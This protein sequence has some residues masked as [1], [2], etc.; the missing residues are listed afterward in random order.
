MTIGSVNIEPAIMNAACSVAKSLDDVQQLATTNIGA[1][2][3]G[4]IT[5]DARKG[6]PTPRWHVGE[7]YALNSFGMP[8]DGAAFYKENLP[9]MIAIAHAAKKKFILSIAGFKTEDYRQLAMLAD[10]ANVDAIELNLG[11][12]NVSINGEQKQ[13]ASFDIATIQE[14]IEA[15]S[16]V[17]R[18]PFTLKLSPYSNPSE[19]KAVAEAIIATDKVSGVVTSNTFANSYMTENGE[20]VV[21]SMFGGLSGHSLLPISLGQVKQ[22]RQILPSHISVI[23]VGGIES[24]EDVR[25]YHDA[26]ADGV[27]AATLIVRDGHAAIDR[28]TQ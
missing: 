4:S 19:L 12:P 26:G 15:T 13:I 14:I 16:E 25:L 3:V 20:P 21:A 7:N 8:N 10:T 17:T 2:V 18:I 23:G 24:P 6:N 27:Q 5:L 1:I 28:L 22:F 11:C 9:K